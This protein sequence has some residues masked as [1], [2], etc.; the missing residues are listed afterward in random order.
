[1]YK[2]Y[3]IA[4]LIFVFKRSSSSNQHVAHAGSYTVLP[5]LFDWNAY[6][7]NRIT[8]NCDAMYRC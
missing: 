5:C 2:M 3:M 1:M 4:V 7:L 8:P 6:L